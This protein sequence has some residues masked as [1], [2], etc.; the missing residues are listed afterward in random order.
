MVSDMM[1][2]EKINILFWIYHRL[3]F[4]K[5]REAS[6]YAVAPLIS[7]KHSQNEGNRMQ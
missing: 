2:K 4:H 1:F 6:S 3:L 7:I 5:D